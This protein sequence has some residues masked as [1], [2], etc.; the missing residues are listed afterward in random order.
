MYLYDKLNFHFERNFSSPEIVRNPL[1]LL[2]LLYRNK[3]I[4]TFKIF[5]LRKRYQN[6]KSTL[7]TLLSIF[8]KRRYE[9]YFH[10]LQ[11]VYKFYMYLLRYKKTEAEILIT[12]IIYAP[13][14]TAL[15]YRKVYTLP[16]ETRL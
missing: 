12:I 1:Y 14:D 3:L 5:K 10:N 8:I 13:I 11:G 7:T 6:H 15:F 9:E 4:E 16:T 2:Y